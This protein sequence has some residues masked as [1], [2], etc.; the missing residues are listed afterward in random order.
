VVLTDH[1]DTSNTGMGAG[2]WWSFY[3]EIHIFITLNLNLGLSANIDFKANF[4]SG[5]MEECSAVQST[6]SIVATSF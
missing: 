4:F 5:I 3:G 1:R 2:E 6:C